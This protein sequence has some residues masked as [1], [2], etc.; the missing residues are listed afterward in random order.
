MGILRDTRIARAPR[1]GQKAE[2]RYGSFERAE[3]KAQGAEFNFHNDRGSR[4]YIFVTE[5]SLSFFTTHR[6]DYTA[7]SAEDEGWVDGRMVKCHARSMN[8]LSST[9]INVILL[10]F[11]FL[12][13]FN[14][15]FSATVFS[16]ASSF[17]CSIAINQ[18]RCDD[19]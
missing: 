4:D 5:N 2:T 18:D 9:P 13:F 6:I 17:S 16:S 12:H 1:R 7:I 10:F 3:G 11:F 15:S 19:T 8:R 14:I